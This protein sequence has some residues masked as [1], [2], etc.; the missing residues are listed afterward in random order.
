MARDGSSISNFSLSVL[1][2]M[3][4]WWFSG[5]AWCGRYGRSNLFSSERQRVQAIPGPNKCSDL[6]VAEAGH[7]RCQNYWVLDS[8]LNLAYSFA[9]SCCCGL[10]GA[11]G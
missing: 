6:V 10:G 4:V 1:A 2:V 3:G 8:W 11:S 7:R 5:W 9:A